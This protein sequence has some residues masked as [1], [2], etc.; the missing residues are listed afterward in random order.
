MNYIDVFQGQYNFPSRDVSEE[1]KDK[2][3]YNLKYTQAMFNRYLADKGGILYSARDGIDLVRSYGKGSQP[4]SIYKSYYQGRTSSDND[5]T[6]L[7]YQR[8]EK[9]REGFENITMR[10]IS[11]LP[12]IKT[13]IKGY[14]DQVGQDV[15]V[16]AI[17]P[18]SNDQKENMKWRMFAIAQNYE[19]ISEYHLKAG[20]PM[21]QLEYLPASM[22]ELNLYEAMGGFKLNFARAMEKLIR[23]TEEISELED[24]LKDAWIDD[25]ADLGLI[26]ARVV[27]DHKIRKYRYRYM[28]PKFLAMQYVK[29]NEYDRSEWGGYV[30]K[31]TISEMKQIM[32]DKPEDYFKGI[33]YRYRGRYGNK[34][35]NYDNE[36]WDN[37]SK[38]MNDGGS[39]NYDDFV[40]EVFEAEW[41]DYECER[42]LIYDSAKGRKST[43]KLSETSEIKELS[44]SKQKR[45][46]KQQDLRTKMRKL[47]GAKW[48]VGT[49]QV[50][51]Y[52][53]VNMQ[54]RPRQ[55]E[56]MHSFRLYCLRD[57]PLTEQLIPIADDMAIAWYRW[58]DDRASL[59]RA[60]YSID[61]SMMENIDSGGKD[62]DFVSILKG[63]RET[64]HLLHQQ[65][66]SGKYEGGT[67]TPVQPIPSM[68]AEA[69]QEFVM[70]WEAALKRIEDVTGLNLVML[71]ATAAQG[72]QVATTQMSAASAVHVLKPIIKVM[73]RMKNNLAETTMRRLQLAFKARP[74]IAEAYT[75]VVGAGD[76]QLLKQAEK[77]AVQYGLSFENRPSEEA[78]NNI[79]QAAMASLQARRD[80]KPGIDISQFLYITQQLESGGNLK[81]LGALL[82]FLMIR[83]EQEIEKSKQQAIQQ[84][85]Q[86]MAQLE[87]QKAQSGAQAQNMEQ[88]GKIQEIDRKGM[89]EI[90]KE[91]VS[92]GAA[93]GQN[94]NTPVGG[95][96]E[97]T[98]GTSP[99]EPTQGPPQV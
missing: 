38:R 71:G 83:S 18:L 82:D 75:D 53:L 80:G 70:T 10:P 61:I 3:D 64:R 78:K 59:P 13:I 79:M 7:T 21:E 66:M 48:I 11:P 32:P 98:G 76:V 88:Q 92:Q 40:I 42:H 17:D 90:R 26:A 77:D 67:T 72:S 55:T 56:V 91:E 45:G 46:V 86:G 19:F 15:F 94:P 14:L 24:F 60:S 28:D 36:Q 41:I 27:Y 65:S 62:F 58:Q 43:L 99:P 52:G 9:T 44:E 6:S 51:D 57:L 85:N 1:T 35:E 16:D 2:G 22:T 30:E 4:S 93:S 96:Q 73:G 95:P 23:H 31:Y 37:F 33:A 5:S 8:N 47:R 74:D 54:D 25:A 12:R 69:L 87:Q 29:N 81:E 34:G 84:Q 20:I 68:V 89:W 49:D 39:Y 63:W 97:P 50:F